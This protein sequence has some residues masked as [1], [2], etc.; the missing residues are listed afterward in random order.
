M[1]FL[2]PDNL[3]V[4]FATRIHVVRIVVILVSAFV[5]TERTVALGIPLRQNVA[6]QADVRDSRPR[7]TVA[8]FSYLGGEP[9][10]EVLSTALPEALAIGLL[11]LDVI[12][13]VDRRTFR[14][15]AT[16]FVAQQPRVR[17]ELVFDEEALDAAGIDLLLRGNFLEYGGKLRV[18]AVLEDRRT[19]EVV[20]LSTAVVDVE[21]VYSAITDLL[22]RI[23][24]EIRS[25]IV[26]RTANRL[27]V[28]CFNEIS[29]T[30]TKLSVQLGEEVAR[31][32]SG[33]LR[34]ERVVVVPW[35]ETRQFCR[36]ERVSS[37]TVLKVLNGQAKSRADSTDAVLSGRY[38]V[39]EGGS[40]LVEPILFATS[41]GTPVPL[42]PVSGNLADLLGLEVRMSQ[43]LGH[44]LDAIAQGGGEWDTGSFMESLGSAEAYID[45]GIDFLRT[46][47]DPYF[48]VLM[49]L[50]AIETEPENAEAHYQ[51]G[52]ARLMQERHYEALGAF[53]Q[54]IALD[55]GAVLAYEGMGDAYRELDELDAAVVAFEDAL[56]VA[57]GTLSVSRKLGDAY[58]LLD[59]LDDA[60]VLYQTVL[61]QDSANSDVSNALAR[62]YRAAGRED[63]AIGE[64]ERVLARD[65]LN[66][67]ARSSLSTL[68]QQQGRAHLSARR[69]G[70]ALVLYERARELQPSATD[71][72]WLTFLLSR[73]QRYETLVAVAEEAERGG[74]Y[75]KPSLYNNKGYALSQ[76]GRWGEAI[77][78]YDRANDLDP[79]Y[80][81]A[82][83]NRA[84]IFVSLRRWE[85]ALASY[86]RA[87]R[88]AP[89]DARGYIGRA[90]TLRELG[91]YEKAVFSYNAAL[92]RDS[93]SGRA[94]KGLA[95]T[96]ITME[97]PDDAYAA[98]A[99]AVSAY[100]N[101][102]ALDSTNPNPYLYRAQALDRLGRYDEARAMYERALE[103]YDR[104]IRRD[105]VNPNAHNFKGWIL[106]FLGRPD[107]ALSEFQAW[108][109]VNPGG[110][111]YLNNSAWALAELHRYEEAVVFAD[112]AI[113]KV[114]AFP[115][116]YNHKGFSLYA[117]GNR[118]EGVALIERAINLNPEYGGSYFNLARVYALEGDLA[119]AIA[120]LKQ[121]V[122][123]S[124]DY[125]RRAQ[126]D[127]LL[128]RLVD[129]SDFRSFLRRRVGTSDDGTTL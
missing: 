73:F 41:I 27:A 108:L 14:V 28:V 90:R 70:D 52:R 77:R 76:L 1:N 13:Y 69:Y 116:S 63:E 93:T 39:R 82:R 31:S 97:R 79:S 7:L 25:L 66:V 3:R 62:A 60:V 115:Y 102:I 68:Y 112:S 94:L 5:V 86:E 51:L 64:W 128:Q 125:R 55:S 23:R 85:E 40:I 100:G 65:S 37:S 101:Q 87:I 91:Q 92:A 96:F 16:P 127:E 36:G 44:A 33:S 49:F 2:I 11:P 81:T 124:G 42:A 119:K 103:A 8:N 15:T 109:K 34:L 6:V 75:N 50:R 26:E 9:R 78:A 4:R 35:G 53:E 22:R 106:I 24:V 123:R 113:A 18:E 99:R 129:H 67:D 61:D 121:A 56:R 47:N 89:S 110:Y 98:F 32:L 46:A 118:D 58:Y 107:E 17:E 84:D 57:P 12:D 71:Y 59:R 72:G 48:A 114:P 126:D 20:E 120:N 83:L 111:T 104:A 21:E 80:L 54:A 88:M 45:R 10:Y 117:M 30:P 19:S 95:R 43:D 29:E 38:A 105:P 122:L 74:Y